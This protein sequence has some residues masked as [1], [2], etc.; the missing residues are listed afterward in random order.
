MIKLKCA[1]LLLALVSPAGGM[2]QNR[3]TEEERREGWTLLFNGKDLAGW[4][5]DPRLWRVE[6]GVMVGA[7]DQAQIEQNTFLIYEKPFADFHLKADVKLRNHNSGIQFRSTAHPGPGWVVS[8]YQADFSEDGEKSAWGNLYEERGRGRRLMKTPEE[9][10]TKGRTVYHKGEWNT[11]EVRAEGSR[12]RLW[13]NG[14]LTIDL[15]DD[16]AQSGVIALQLHRGD[17]MRVEFRNVK[18]KPLAAVNAQRSETPYRVVDFPDLPGVDCPCG[19]AR[20]AFADAAEFP[21]TVHV[22]DISIDA[23]LHYHKRLTEVYYVLECGPGAAMQLNDDRIPLKVGRSVL[24]PPGVRH[25]AIGKM[26]VLIVVFPKF[27]PA[28][29]WTP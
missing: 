28:D 11:I 14:L 25:R 17:P 13:L 12:L 19:T 27:D 18:L 20:R 1:I 29:E 2:A 22:T 24:I 4:S 16:K 15:T 21:G 26:T 10:W 23:A 9:G 7:T 8:G 6:D 3:L 5:G